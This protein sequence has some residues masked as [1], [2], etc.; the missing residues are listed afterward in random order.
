VRVITG[1]NGNLGRKLRMHLEAEDGYELQLLDLDA[2]G[3]PG[4]AAADLSVHDKAWARHFKGIDAV[5]HLA[6]HAG[7]QIDWTT[8]QR[9]N[10]DL[11]FN[12]YNAA[13]LKGAGRMV[14][15]S[16]NWVMAG[17]RFDD[18]RLTT[19]RPPRPLNPLRRIEADWRTRRQE[20]CR[21]AQCPIH[22]PADRLLPAG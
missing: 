18:V 5:L 9:L 15:A 17:Y 11:T 16:S 10:I 4:V 6:A 22:R 12:V 19:D 8:A 21:A 1:A 7:P 2:A 13:A 20:P 14:F 3:T